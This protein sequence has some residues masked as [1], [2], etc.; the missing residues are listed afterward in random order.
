M[1]LKIIRIEKTDK[2]TIGKL[3]VDN[4]FECYT[5]EDVVRE[6]DGVSVSEWKIKGETAIPRGTYEVYV[7]KSPRFN[8]LLPRLKNVEGFDGVLIHTGNTA[9]NTEG[10]ILVGR[11]K[12]KDTIIDSVV[13]FT[14]LMR[15]INTAI[16]NKETITITIEG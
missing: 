11:T 6:I 15:K 13:A 9:K 3:Y 7:T 10:C 1:K 16:E 5:L 2:S 8:K 14:P 4:Q 12:G